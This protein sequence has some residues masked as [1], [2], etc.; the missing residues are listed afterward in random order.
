MPRKNYMTINAHETI[1]EMF[2]EFTVRR[3][4]TKTVALND[5]LEM[6][7]IAKDEEL[8]LELKKK[9]LNI[10]SVRQM[11]ADRDSSDPIDTSEEKFIFMKLANSRDN[12]GNE[13][14][15]H[16]TMQLYIADQSQ[17]GYTWFST[18]ALFYG[19]SPKRVEAYNKAIGLGDKVTILFAIGRSA[20]GDNDIAY[21]AN[22]LEIRSYTEP[23]KL[24]TDEYPSVWHGETARIWIKMDN[25]SPETILTARL[26]EITS[27]GMDLQQVIN[28]SQYHFGYINLKQ[29]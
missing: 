28:N 1:Q 7:M 8:Y 6:Y 29:N 25:L 2:E 24:P 4:L 10:E 17:R 11:L 22:V 18:Q 14:S 15:A 12:Q 13:Y 3:E 20:G 19:M 9:Y 16:E 23:Q 26:F 5:M 27:T 21:K